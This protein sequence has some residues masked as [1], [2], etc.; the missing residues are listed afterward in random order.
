MRWHKNTRAGFATLEGSR[1]GHIGE[2]DTNATKQEDDIHR[3]E[4]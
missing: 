4:A 2:P 1:T 3:L